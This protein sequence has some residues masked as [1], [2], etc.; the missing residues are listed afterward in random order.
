MNIDKVVVE[1]EKEEDILIVHRNYDMKA[2]T[3]YYNLII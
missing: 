1:E 3:K 2:A